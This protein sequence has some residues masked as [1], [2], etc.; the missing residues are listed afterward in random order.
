MD[1][2]ARCGQIDDTRKVFDEM[3]VRDRFCWSQMMFA[4]KN[5]KRPESALALYQEM[6]QNNVDADSVIMVNVASAVAQLR[7]VV[8]AQGIH[9]S[10]MKHGFVSDWYLQAAMVDM[11]AKCGETG[12]AR[13]IFD[14]MRLKDSVCWT[15]M[16]TAYEQTSQ[17]RES[18]G[19]FLMM[20]RNRV[21]ADSVTLI[22]VVSAIAQVG[23]SSRAKSVHAYAVSSGFVKDASVGNSLIA[24]Y[25][26]C[27]QTEEARLVFDQMDRKDI[28]SWNSMLSGYVQNGLACEAFTLF[29]EMLAS[30]CKPGS[31]TA[32]VIVSACTYLRSS[33][34]GRKMHDL[35]IKNKIKIDTNVSNALME[36]YAKCGD[37][38]TARDIFR[39]IHPSQRDVKS[40]NAMIS[41]HGMHGHGEKALEFYSKMKEQ[42]IKPDR[43]TF[44]SV[45][46]A[47]SHAGLFVQGRKC[48]EEMEEHSVTRDSRHYACVVD[49]LGRLGF[50]REAHDLVKGMEIE[51]DDSVWGALLLACRI[52][53]DIGLGNMAARNLCRKHSG[54]YVLMSNINATF[55]RWEEVIQ[56]RREMEVKGMKKPAALSALDP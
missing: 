51:P 4:Y 10:A 1:M 27:G 34:L 12:E 20:Q 44:L 22:S 3:R 42:G 38:E 6:K 48:F 14:E 7:S 45:L 25:A 28:I 46:S 9:G 21:F 36:M 32:L 50:L 43:I 16:I 17:P 47:C 29:N 5:A 39:Q 15:S 49:M 40:W 23:G 31:V 11:Y 53:G 37:L 19:L 18:I 41:G 13:R 55:G 33:Q 56:L 26:K 54:C 8:L 35:I 52:H 24:M 2:Y 30:E